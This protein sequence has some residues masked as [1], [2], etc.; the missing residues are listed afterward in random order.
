MVKLIFTLVVIISS[1]LVGNSFSVRLANRRKTL[2]SIV[3]A[4]TRAKTLICFGG[5]DTKRVIEECF[6]TEAFPLLDTVELKSDNFDVS[7]K[8]SVNKISPA[9]SLNKS[10][11]ELLKDFGTNLGMTDVT[12]QVAHAELYAELFSER[13]KQVKA[14]ENEK[15]KLYRILGFSVGSAISLLIA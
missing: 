4:I 2:T 10:D 11:K 13:L 14:Q 3:S 5:I 12:G 1:C 15:S 7:F 6:C 9:F 8:S